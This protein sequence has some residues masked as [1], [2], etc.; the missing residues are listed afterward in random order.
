M[1]NY[2]L[3]NCNSSNGGRAGGLEVL[4]NNNV[5]LKILN[6]NKNFIDCYVDLCDNN[7]VWRITGIYGY[8][9]H[10]KKIQT[11]NLLNRIAKENY[12][13]NW[14]TFGDFN[15]ILKNDDKM[16]G[17]LSDQNI[18]RLFQQTL[19][20]CNLMD[21]G[22][23]GP[24]YTWTNNQEGEYH[25][26]ERLHR[27]FATNGWIS[28]YP[29]YTNYHI[30]HF[31]S[32]HN[33]ILLEFYSDMDHKQTT[34]NIGKIKRF[35]QIWA[36][37]EE[38]VQIVKDTWMNNKGSCNHRLKDVLH[39]LDRYGSIINHMKICR[40]ILKFLRRRAQQGNV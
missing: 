29:I 1:T 25:I 8:S 6:F 18:I 5:K 17:N 26:K 34:N 19:S 20:N 32:D 39:N 13:E 11:C 12:N 28:N 23:E 2:F 38:S 31:S 14:L 30:S 10:N 7:N 40:S 9:D 3:I 33:P 36:E 37:D 15:M 16:G 24:K 22:Y 21:L 4:W 35:E 27:F